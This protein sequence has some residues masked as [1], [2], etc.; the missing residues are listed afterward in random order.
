MIASGEIRTFFDDFEILSHQE[1]VR[2]I[3]SGEFPR[4]AV[5]GCCL[6]LISF[7][8]PCPTEMPASFLIIDRK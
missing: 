1:F 2:Q 3:E 4:L 5:E 8:I 7:H 6:Q